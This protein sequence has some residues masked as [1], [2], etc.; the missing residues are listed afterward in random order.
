MSTVLKKNNFQPTT[1]GHL[2][3]LYGT[4]QFS[5]F[6]AGFHVCLLPPYT[7]VCYMVRYMPNCMPS[8]L[9]LYIFY[10][11]TSGFWPRRLVRALGAPIFLAQ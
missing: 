7:T 11:L 10:F 8:S 1:L 4:L 5:C 2:S 9:T 3:L 6:S